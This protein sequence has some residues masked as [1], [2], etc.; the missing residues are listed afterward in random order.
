MGCD[1]L[2]Q[3]RARLVQE[4]HIKCLVTQ[5]VAPLKRNYTSATT[6]MPRARVDARADP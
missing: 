2:G 5:S 4:P 3:V 6:V 1:L